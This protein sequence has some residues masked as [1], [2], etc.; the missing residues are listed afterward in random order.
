MSG[1][2]NDDPHWLFDEEAYK[3]H[4]SIPTRKLNYDPDDPEPVDDKWM[5]D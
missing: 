4:H 3:E 2:P 1:R 5:R